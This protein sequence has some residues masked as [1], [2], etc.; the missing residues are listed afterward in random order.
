MNQLP[1]LV[2]ITSDRGLASLLRPIV[3]AVA[4]ISHFDHKTAVAG[5]G[6]ALFDAALID[7]HVPGRMASVLARLFLYHNPVSRLAVIGGSADN[8]TVLGLAARDPRV[9]VFFDPLD[10][11]LIR[12]WAYAAIATATSL[13]VMTTA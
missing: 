11:E 7:A 6:N 2:L 13:R 5:L 3:A 8:S 10:P 4:D 1:E 9:E 12:R